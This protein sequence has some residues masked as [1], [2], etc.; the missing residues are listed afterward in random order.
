MPMLSTPKPTKPARTSI[1]DHRKNR[2]R[3]RAIAAHRPAMNGD[4][5]END[6]D[7]GTSAAVVWGQRFARMINE[8]R[9]FSALGEAL[10]PNE[11]QT[12]IAYGEA[13]GSGAISVAV[14]ADWK[15]AGEIAGPMQAGGNF[16]T[17]NEM[18]AALIIAAAENL[19]EDEL[20]GLLQAVRVL[21][22][23]VVHPAAARA[24]MRARHR[25]PELVRNAAEAATQTCVQA[26][27]VLAAGTEESHPFV[28]KYHLFELGRWPLGMIGQTLHLF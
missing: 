23:R 17:E 7:F 3:Y 14:A 5:T 24:A 18:E 13:L 16:A 25:G 22:L 4:E 10:R 12:A 15:E 11:R 2:S 28:H 21:A 6:D 20:F 27:L 19:T 9:W 26:A 1:G 8:V